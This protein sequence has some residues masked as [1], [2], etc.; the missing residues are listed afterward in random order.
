MGQNK[1]LNS[2]RV[3]SMTKPGRY[4]DGNAL[5]LIVAPSGAKR[6]MLRTVVRGRRRD[7]GLGSTRLVTLADARERASHF[8]RI[9]RDGGDPLSEKKKSQLVVPT[10]AEAARKVHTAHSTAWKN[11][12]HASQWINT[13][14]EYVFPHLGDRRV[15][16]ITT[17]DVLRAL[18]PSG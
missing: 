17:P 18:S 4:G 2:V 12:K 1:T 3:R 13:L 11:S 8:R 16:E 9:A 5:Y 6:W 10:F 7:F 14:S 15:D